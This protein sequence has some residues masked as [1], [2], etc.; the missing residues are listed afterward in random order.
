MGDRSSLLFHD[1]LTKLRPP[2]STVHSFVIK[3]IN[4]SLSFTTQI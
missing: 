3:I 4:G 1:P 2:S